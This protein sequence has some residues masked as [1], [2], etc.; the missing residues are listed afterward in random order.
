[1]VND[2]EIRPAAE[3]AFATT[4]AVNSYL[5]RDWLQYS[6]HG[7]RYKVIVYDLRFYF[8]PRFSLLAGS[9]GVQ[10]SR[11]SHAERVDAS[12]NLFL[13]K[14]GSAVLTRI[15]LLPIPDGFCLPISM[16]RQTVRTLIAYGGAPQPFPSQNI[17][18]LSCIWVTK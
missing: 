4:S 17:V 1:M 10:L 16:T 5:T 12:G 15:I 13:S 18:A 2:A 6:R 14:P 8:M 11:V 9:S 3:I 7:I